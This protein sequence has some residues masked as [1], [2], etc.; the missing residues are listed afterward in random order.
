[1][2]QRADETQK[3]PVM[4]L[5]GE[6]ASALGVVRSFG[7][8]GI[9]VFVGGRSVRPV[10]GFSRFAT[11]QFR[12]S[13][14]DDE[15]HGQII[16][17]LREWRPQVLLP[18]MDHAWSM[19]YI[20]CD[21][22]AAHTTVIPR[23]DPDLRAVL[24]DKARLVR[25]AVAN[26]VPVP[27]TYLPQSMDQALEL[28]PD[29]PYP[30]LLKPATG[31]AGS[32]IRLVQQPGDLA[33]AMQ[34]SEGVPLIQEFV[35]GED[36]EL[37]ILADHGEPVAGSAYVTLRNRPTYGPPVACRTIRDEHLMNIGTRFLRDLKYHGVAHL[38]FR[39]D[40]R[41][42]LP[43]LLDFNVRLAGSNEISTRT[44]VDFALMLYQMALGRRVEP[45]FEYEVDTEF[46]WPMYGELR[47]LARSVNKRA[48]LRE[49]VH[50]RGVETDVVLN[51]PMPHFIDTLNVFADVSKA[52]ADR[53]MS[54]D[55]ENV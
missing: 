43:K 9:P 50:W 23:P 52:V 7:R 38:D 24:G 27:R 1:M 46:R 39:R 20:H 28:E 33:D 51:D 35:K 40:E 47:H 48:V 49:L 53:V 34:A 54:R 45:C 2:I 32:G 55:G 17:K 26:D 13:D 37:T 15:A 14:A 42:D 44:G 41:D 31:T 8:R 29:L 30:V 25:A 18:I 3:P 12:Y 36:L 11:R 22:Y 6:H 19:V 5:G 21:D 16:D 10:A 4:I